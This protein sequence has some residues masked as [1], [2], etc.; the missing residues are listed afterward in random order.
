MNEAE[1]KKVEPIAWTSD[2]RRELPSKYIN[3]EVRLNG[4]KVAHCYACAPHAVACYVMEPSDTTRSG[5]ITAG[6][7]DECECSPEI[8]AEDRAP[9][10]TGIAPTLPH[11]RRV[12]RYGN[13]TLHEKE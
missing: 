5:V 2:V 13:V 12:V 7:Y 6:C 1:S 10:G 11:P 4:E 3:T 9:R 8:Q